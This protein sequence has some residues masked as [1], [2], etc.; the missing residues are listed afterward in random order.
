MSGSF[1]P[2]DPEAA[3]KAVALLKSL[4]HV[5]RLRILCSLVDQD[6]TVGELSI[7]LREPQASVSQQLMRLRAEGLVR[8]SR[9]G[10][11]VTNSLGRADI[12]P[13]IATL[14]EAFCTK[15]GMDP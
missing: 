13:V 12:I 9:Q 1:A 8:S 11:H 10:K 14:R 5:G 2:D 4:S 3:A 15:T 6:M 7:A